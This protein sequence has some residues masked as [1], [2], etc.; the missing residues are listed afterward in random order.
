MFIMFTKSKVSRIVM[1]KILGSNINI[2][3]DRAQSLFTNG[4]FWTFSFWHFRL[5]V[6]M[7]DTWMNECLE[8]NLI[9]RCL[10]FKFIMNVQSS[11]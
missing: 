2:Q 6:D 7:V 10:T 8:K 4:K 9:L 11:N 1:E 3:N 5:T